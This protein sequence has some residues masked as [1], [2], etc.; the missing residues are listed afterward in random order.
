M[1]RRGL[2]LLELLS[3]LVII[4]M[5][6]GL[7]LPA[8]QSTREAAR[9]A[10]CE[11]NL[12]QL[13][14]AT[15]A[16]WMANRLYPCGTMATTLPVQ[17]FPADNHQGWLLRVAPHWS[18]G[19]LQIKDFDFSRSVYDPVNWPIAQS[20][21]NV[22]DCTSSPLG[23]SW[24]PEQAFSSYVGIYDGRFIPLDDSSRGAFTANRFLKADDFA[25][26]LSTTAMISEV[27]AIYTLLGWTSGTSATLRT[28]GIPIATTG[29]SNWRDQL[30]QGVSS[31]YGWYQGDQVQSYQQFIDSLLTTLI[32]RGVVRNDSATS[33]DPLAGLS[34]EAK[35]TLIDQYQESVLFVEA[36]VVDWMGDGNATTSAIVAEDS[37]G[38][39]ELTDDGMYSFDGSMELDSQILYASPILGS[40]RYEPQG[41]GSFH[42]A[43]VNMVFADGHSAFITGTVDSDYFSAIGI[44]NDNA[45]LW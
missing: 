16:Y 29:F 25:D 6:V 24:D 18:G 11:N 43:G 41:V 8:V 39:M 2:T 4:G 31:P 22:L 12:R 23:R 34:P 36:E 33:A 26:G 42:S 35:Q 1:I 9:R 38:M 21:P 20:V 3:V 30:D 44:R 17:N 32:R 5:L 7:L 10:A 45:P 28:T 40:Q 15:E 19:N 27:T 37:M 14:L 13:W